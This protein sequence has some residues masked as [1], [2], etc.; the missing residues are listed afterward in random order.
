[1]TMD[2]LDTQ[3][4]AWNQKSALRD[5]YTRWHHDIMEWLTAGS[6]LEI[7]CGIGRFKDLVPNI[8]TLDIL[9][10]KWTDIVGDAHRL[11]VKTGT[12]ANLVLFD[13]LHHLPRPVLFFREA[14]RALQPKGRVVIVDPYISFLSGWVYRRFHPEPVIMDCD[15]LSMNSPLSSNKPFDS[16][17]AIATVLFYK[18]MERWRNTFPEFT[19]LHRRRFALL[20]Y[21][22]TGG[23]GG[24]QVLPDSA[25]HLLGRLEKLLFP[26]SPLF[27]FRT[28]IVME[29]K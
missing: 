23:F 8:Q 25:I 14:L 20:A 5:L 2:I 7:G 24:V 10:S 3:R 12:V 6:T 29:K 13:V 15:P 16:N 21:P 17:Q 19:I 28:I 26:I 1:M 27:A 9:F 22:A 11:P 18:K 4:A